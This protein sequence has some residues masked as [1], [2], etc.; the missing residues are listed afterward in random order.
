MSS[1]LREG[2]HEIGNKLNKLS[3]AAGYIKALMGEL[4]I[5][6]KD[7]AIVSKILSTCNALESSVVEA[8]Q[9]INGLKS[10]VYRKI[11]PDE[12]LEVVYKEIKETNRTLNLFILDDDVGLC[13]M[14]KDT[15]EKKGMNVQFSV[16]GEG[17]LKDLLTDFKPDMAILDLHLGG[18]LTGLDVLVFMKRELPS[19]INL[20]V[21]KEDDEKVLKKI[22]ETG[23]FGVLA[24]PLT[25]QQLDTKING[26]IHLIKKD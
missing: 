21:T 26:M 2:F 7:K 3:V 15:Y 20:V 1:T 23:V 10:V 4:V 16:S 14:L 18:D 6:E 25:F 5:T 13:E 17:A 11:N 19:C 22:N 8:D 12:N 24:K 9:K